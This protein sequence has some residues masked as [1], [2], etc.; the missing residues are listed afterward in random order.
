MT[1]YDMSKVMPLTHSK[2]KHIITRDGFSVT[3]FVLTKETGKK[4]LVDMSAVR[5]M[6][7]DEFFKMMHPESEANDLNDG[8]A[9]ER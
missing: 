3:G 2:A 5:W 6:S 4:C 7:C 9:H 8:L 1:E